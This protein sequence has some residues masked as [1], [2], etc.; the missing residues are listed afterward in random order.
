MATDPAD[1]ITLVFVG[2]APSAQAGR[3][4]E[5][6]DAV[7]ALLADHGARLAYRGRRRNDQDPTL[8]FEVHLLWFPDRA[9]FDAYLTDDRRV[10]L[11]HRFGEVFTSKI[12]V[13]MD[14]ISVDPLPR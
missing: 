8:P 12:V 3:A 10:E 9:A 11:L 2:H 13:E 1:P 4:A 6:E 7:L 14:T 5:Y